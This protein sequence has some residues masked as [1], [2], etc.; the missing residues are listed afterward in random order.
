MTAEE[1]K[2]KIKTMEESRKN[3]FKHFTE[4]IKRLKSEVEES[5]MGVA[6]V[7][8]TVNAIIVEMAKKYGSL[9]EDGSFLLDIGRPRLECVNEYEL[10]SEINVADEHMKIRVKKNAEVQE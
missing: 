10:M 9:E 2:E 3:M 8:E 4:R 6:Q 7:N 5:K 1:M